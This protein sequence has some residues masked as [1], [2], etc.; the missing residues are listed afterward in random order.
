MSAF[1]TKRTFCGAARMSAFGVRADIPRPN[2]KVPIFSGTDKKSPNSGEI[3]M[4]VLSLAAIGF[5]VST[6]AFSQNGVL[7]AEQPL[8]GVAIVIEVPGFVDFL[9]PYELGSAWVMDPRNDAVELI[10]DEGV[11]ASVE[12]P[13]PAGTMVLDFGSL[14]IA[15]EDWGQLVRIDPVER[16]IIARIDAAIVEGESN[17][18]SAGG[19]IWMMTDYDGTL[20]RIDPDSNTIIGSVQTRPDSL[21]LV[22][23]FG[24]VWVSNRGPYDSAGVGSVQRIDPASNQV[25]ATIPVGPTPLFLVA[26]EGGVWVLNQGDGS[27]SRVDPESN[28]VVATIPLGV[29]GAGGDIAAGL[30]RIWVRATKTFLSVI[31]SETN[32]VL[33]RYGPPAGS[34]AVRVGHGSVWLTAHDVERVYRIDGNAGR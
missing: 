1:G 6:V 26:G 31:D 22:A 7:V 25:V 32:A 33:A 10:T 18:A 15:S 9:E 8:E 28:A 16:V 27:V 14:W 11:V 23:G 29:D 17:L 30:G 24:S 19:S 5:F 13:G 21:G 4:R 20:L 3:S 2:R 34:G 12:V